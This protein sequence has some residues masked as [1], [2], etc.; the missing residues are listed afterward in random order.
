MQ[1]GQSP[2]EFALSVVERLVKD[3]GAVVTE[4]DLGPDGT[5][6]LTL[7]IPTPRQSQEG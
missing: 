5:G 6:T 4:V 1:N 3:L 2:L 7:E